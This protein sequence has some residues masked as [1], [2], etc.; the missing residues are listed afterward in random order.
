MLGVVSTPVLGTNYEHQALVNAAFRDSAGESDRTKLIAKQNVAWAQNFIKTVESQTTSGGSLPPFPDPMTYVHTREFD[1]PFIFMKVLEW[2]NQARGKPI[3]KLPPALIT[4][5]KGT[6]NHSNP[7]AGLTPSIRGRTFV[8]FDV[9]SIR[10]SDCPGV[11]AP[12]A[13]GLTS[14][15][16]FLMCYKAGVSENVCLFDMSEF[17]PLVEGYATAK[18]LA[19]MF[20]HFVLG[21]QKRLTAAALKFCTSNPVG[22]S[23]FAA[24]KTTAAAAI[25]AGAT[26]QPP[27]PEEMRTA[28]FQVINHYTTAPVTA[29]PTAAATGTANTTASAK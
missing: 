21:F 17:N 11:S 2:M 1:V 22:Q 3:T 25:A 26:E 12:G 6:P 29:S 13:I 20:Y 28:L 27:M 8:S 18:L 16:A 4:A 5:P 14:E 19:G 10:A 15:E 9:D 23:L 7:T 24:Y